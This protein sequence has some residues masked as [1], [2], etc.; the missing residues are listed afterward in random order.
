MLNENV[1]IIYLSITAYLGSAAARAGVFIG[2]KVT[3][4]NGENVVHASL[5][6]VRQLIPHSK[7]HN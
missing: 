2:D 6:T 4:V 7:Y 3:A 1:N 5:E